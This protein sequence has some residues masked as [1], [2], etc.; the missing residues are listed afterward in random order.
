MHPMSF[1][2]HIPCLAGSAARH[3]AMPSCTHGQWFQC[4]G[5][6]VCNLIHEPRDHFPFHFSKIPKTDMHHVTHCSAGGSP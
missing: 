4:H 5:I 1:D 3:T 6:N 2:Q